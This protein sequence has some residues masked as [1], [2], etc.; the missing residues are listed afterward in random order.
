MQQ[1]PDHAKLLEIEKDA[2]S[3]FLFG[4]LSLAL[5]MGIGLIFQIMNFIKINS[6][7]FSK[8][9][10]GFVFPELD[11]TAAEAATYESLKQKIKTGRLLT[12]IGLIITGV[13]LWV[14]FM[15]LV[16]GITYGF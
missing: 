9:A 5:S 7:Y 13:L 14:L 1:S 16:I 8:T 15:V 6:K 3:I 10:K 2:K 11:L 4:I 12:L